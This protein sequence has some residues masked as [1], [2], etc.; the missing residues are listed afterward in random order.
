MTQL[1]STNPDAGVLALDEERS[2]TTSRLADYAT[3]T[4]PRITLM[5]AITAWLGFALGATGP[6]AW[7]VL[8]GTLIGTSLSCMGASVLN[9][10]L[11]RDTDALMHR[12]RR[13]PIAAGRVGP[14]EG[15]IF[16]LLLSV[17]GVVVLALMTTALAAWISGLTI[18]SYVLIYTPMKRVSPWAL[19]VGAVPGAAP[20]LIGFAAATGTLG[21]GAWLVFA[22]MFLWQIPH[23]LAISWLY[24]ED[25]ARAG[26]R[27]L[28]VLD[29]DGSRTFRQVLIYCL[30]LVPVGALPTVMGVSGWW[31]LGIV[32]VCGLG[33]L[34]LGVD[35]VRQQDRHR[36]RRLFLGSLLYL[37][38]VLAAIVLNQA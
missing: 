20:P 17:G 10:V 29:S 18:L 25:Y 13:R 28:A 30:L 11:E 19:P 3:L 5:V 2:A 23:F 12:T 38:V 16:G 21:A 33:F 32:M 35:L 36:A 22:I 6:W 37:P 27:M 8:L 1:T 15:A 26:L 34:A 9:Q 31:S 7:L 24:R 4:K 14:L